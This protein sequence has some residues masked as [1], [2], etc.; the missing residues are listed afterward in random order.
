[1]SKSGVMLRLARQLRGFPQNEAA[2]CLRVPNS[3]LSRIENGLKEPSEQLLSAAAETFSVPVEFFAQT[4]AIYGAPVSVHAPMWRKKSDVSA[5]E[6]HRIVAE[7]N[8][9]VMHLRKLLEATDLEPVNKLPRFDADEYDNDPEKIAVLVRRFWQVPD[10]PIQDVTALVEDAG[11]LVTHSDLGG[12]SVSGV[13]FS[14]PGMPHVIVLNRQQS[15]DRMRFTLC[16]E[17]G[18]VIM[19]TFP[20]PDMEAEADKFASCFLLP[21]EDIKPAFVGRRVDLR[22]LA[23]LKPEWKVS[24]A[25]LVFAAQR[26]GALNT[27]QAQYIWKQFNIHKIRLREPPELD[28]APEEPRTV[29]DLFSLHINDMGYSLA[30]LSKMLIMNETEVAKTYSINLPGQD[31]ARG[32][33]LRI[34]Q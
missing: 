24:M 1:M 7:L 11:I 20:T 2:E 4:D 33:H 23:S 17:L 15:A 18:H 25:S 5:T 9:R 27:T 12:S 6:L 29:S 19:H 31:K 28:F 26:A 32:A 3:E 10:G 21:T 22:L 34:I 16:H 8:I 13:R 30:D 14:V